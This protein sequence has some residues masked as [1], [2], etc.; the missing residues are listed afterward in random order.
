[1]VFI[2]FI[3]IYFGCI[4]TT[5]SSSQNT[6][7]FF[8]EGQKLYDSA[9]LRHQFQDFSTVIDYYWTTLFS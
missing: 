3:E 4:W 1:M 2:W 7:F 5:W 6:F 9:S 8:Y